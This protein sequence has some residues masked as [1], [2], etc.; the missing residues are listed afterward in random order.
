MSSSEPIGN[1]DLGILIIIVLVAQSTVT[2]TGN[3]FRHIIATLDLDS[4]RVLIVK[5]LPFRAKE[6]DL[7]EYFKAFGKVNVTFDDDKDGVFKQSAKVYFQRSQDALKALELDGEEFLG[8]EISIEMSGSA[9]D[10]AAPAQVTPPRRKEDHPFVVVNG[11][12]EDVKHEEIDA[13]FKQ[14]GR[15]LS[16]TVKRE[17][18]ICQGYAFLTY[19]SEDSVRKALTRNGSKLGLK[20][21]QITVK[22]GDP[23]MRKTGGSR[24]RSNSGPIRSSTRGSTGSKDRPY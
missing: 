13:H 4:S 6:A 5:N 14:C 21:T 20:Q 17:P 15:P 9:S 10:F 11:L 3:I 8:R 12:P 18:G 1:G 7:A 16:V 23:K 22:R 19:E 24:S 2:W